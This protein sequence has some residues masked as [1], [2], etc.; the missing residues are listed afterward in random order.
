MRLN[1]KI[2]KNVNNV[3]SWVYASQTFMQEGQANSFHI[4]LVD[5]DQSIL[6]SPERSPI[7]PE[8]PIR[9]L[10]SA[11]E[12]TVS[13][14]FDDLDDDLEITIAGTQPFALDKSIWKFD[15]TDAQKPASGA[16]QITVTEDGVSR[17]FYMRASLVMETSNIGSC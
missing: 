17:S 2:L 12:I 8:A 7:N 14:K 9:Y 10:S 15:L 4:Q 6:A 13:A 5:M 3:N 11:T 16:I 1:A